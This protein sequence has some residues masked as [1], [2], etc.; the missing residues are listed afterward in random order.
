MNWYAVRWTF[1]IIALLATVFSF[2]ITM[3]SLEYG[4]KG[5]AIA[6]LIGFCAL[7]VADALLIGSVA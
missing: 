7:M 2:A 6:A 5:E 4:T 3:A 1:L